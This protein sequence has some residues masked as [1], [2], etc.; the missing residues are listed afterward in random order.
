MHL[1]LLVERELQ[2]LAGGW[3]RLGQGAVVVAERI[4][5]DPLGAVHAAQVAVVGRLEPG[6]AH[7]VVLGDA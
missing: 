2:V 3:R 5:L 6:L 1:E 7:R 4:H